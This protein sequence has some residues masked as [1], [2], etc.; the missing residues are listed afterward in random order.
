MAQYMQMDVLIY[1]NKIFLSV[2]I[3]IA[4][5]QLFVCFSSGS[6][7]GICQLSLSL[8]RLCGL[9]CCLLLYT[10][11]SRHIFVSLFGPILSICWSYRFR[12]SSIL[13]IFCLFLFVPAIVSTAHIRLGVTT[14]PYFFI[15]P[16]VDQAF[17]PS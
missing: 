8:N 13:F 2:L 6:A 7:R 11:Y 1:N 16:S 10:L 15:L 9:S 14:V 17:V 4:T 5:L 3:R 12:L